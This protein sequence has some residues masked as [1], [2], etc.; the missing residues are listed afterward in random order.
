MWWQG[1]REG[2][3]KGKRLLGRPRS[4]PEKN[5]KI[6]VKGIGWGIELD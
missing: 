4:R 5:I 3:G 6:Y 1:A 2:G